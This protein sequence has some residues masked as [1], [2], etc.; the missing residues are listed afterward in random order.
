MVIDHIAWAFVDFYS[1]LGQ[2]MHVCGRLAIPIMCYFVAEGYRNT[3]DIK[4]YI[5]RMITFGVLSIIPF[6]LF[7]H[8][9]YGY[10]QNIIFDLLGGL[11]AIT[12]L[13][14][15]KKKWQKVVGMVAIFGVSMLVG[16]WPIAPILFIIIFYFVI[17]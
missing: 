4:R 9:E 3:K 2:F 12:L 1:P 17:M 15:A 11:L 10:R 16:G 7:F 8:D 13:D 6:Y 5:D 14:R